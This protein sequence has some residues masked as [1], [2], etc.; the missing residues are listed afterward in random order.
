MNKPEQITARDLGKKAHP[1]C[2]KCGS[3][4]VRTEAFAAWNAI[5]QDWMIADLLDGNQVCAHCGQECA[6]QWRLQ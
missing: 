4:E 2:D 6:I 1:V 5:K 3:H